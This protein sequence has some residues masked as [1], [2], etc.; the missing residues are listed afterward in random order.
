[1]EP[2]TIASTPHVSVNLAAGSPM[3][4]TVGAHGGMIGVGV[5]HRCRADD[6][7]R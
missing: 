4:N 6:H 5:P 2:F 3:I 7:I 1:M